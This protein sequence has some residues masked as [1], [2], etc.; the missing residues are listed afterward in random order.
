MNNEFPPPQ[1]SNEAKTW[2]QR[3]G[4]LAKVAIVAVPSMIALSAV[5]NLTEG[6]DDAAASDTTEADVLDAEATPETSASTTE[7]VD[8]EVSVVPTT[9]SPVTDTAPTATEPEMTDEEFDELTVGLAVDLT[10]GDM[11]SA[12][13]RTACDGWELLGDEVTISLLTAE[14]DGSEAETRLMGEYW[15]TKLEQECG[16]STSSDS[17]SNMTVA[18]ENALESAESYLDY[19]A[20]S[21]TGLIEQLEYEQY[22]TADATWAV[23]QLDV[24]WNEQAALSAQSYLDYSSFSRQGLIDQLVYEGFTADQAT[25]GV[26][27]VGL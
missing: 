18:Q 14:V 26:N 20:F 25:Y 27:Q 13:R 1:P 12:D 6:E 24:D 11:D 4:K 19:T 15:L 2:W 7:P 21:R 22:D 3:R 5:A 8:V 10:W 23:D 16:S 17:P 9:E